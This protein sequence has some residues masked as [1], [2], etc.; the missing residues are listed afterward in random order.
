[1]PQC[2]FTNWRCLH[3]AFDL[4][5]EWYSTAHAIP[6]CTALYDGKAGQKRSLIKP[7]PQLSHTDPQRS[8]PQLVTS[9]LC[10]KHVIEAKYSHLHSP[11]VLHM[12]LLQD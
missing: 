4:P 11:H 9:L 5:D 7:W 10:H 6:R 8:D 3:A 1:M 2:I 12:R